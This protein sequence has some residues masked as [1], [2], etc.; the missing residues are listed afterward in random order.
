MKTATIPA[1]HRI[2]GMSN[3]WTAGSRGALLFIGLVLLV[4]PWTEHFW[5]FDGFLN[6]GQDFEFG[7]LAIA[8]MFCF[9]MVMMQHAKCSFRAT[10]CLRRWLSIVLQ[11]N[12]PVVTGSFMGLNS[13]LHTVPFPSPSLRQCTLPLQ[14]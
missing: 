10:L 14:I 12:D 7:L 2:D 3:L 1:L 13:I 9:V 4:M 5:N 11:H 8:T 6:G